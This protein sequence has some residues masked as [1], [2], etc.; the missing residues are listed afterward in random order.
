MKLASKLFVFSADDTLHS[1]ANTAFMR[2]LRQEDVA[3][4]PAFAGQRVRQASV[5][6]EVVDGSPRRVV[7]Q[8]FSV[9]DFD[10]DGLLDVERLN[11]Q[12]IA[13]MDARFDRCDPSN[14]ICSPI[15]DAT[16][17]FVAR[18]GTWQPDDNLL[19]RIEAAALGRSPCP[20]VR[21][22]R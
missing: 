10:P 8:T 5:A 13:R 21:V 16:S 22:V 17:R 19:G 12:Q 2:M 7:H 20:R 6:V 14:D 4:V 9:L 1:M 3:R 11:V 18:G 15:V